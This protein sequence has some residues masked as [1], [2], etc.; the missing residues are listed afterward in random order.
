MVASVVLNIHNKK[1]LSLL[2]SVRT[3]HFSEQSVFHIEYCLKARSFKTKRIH[4]CWN[5]HSNSFKPSS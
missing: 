3:M 1:M 4:L 5:G 2:G